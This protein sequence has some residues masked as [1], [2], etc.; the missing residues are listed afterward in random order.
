MSSI[1]ELRKLGKI[2]AFNPDEYLFYQGEIEHFA[3]LILKG[4]VSVV[5]DSAYDGS[6][7]VLAE[8]GEG[9]MVGE[10]AI[11][12]NQ[13]RSASVK[14]LEPVVALRLE[15]ES[16][17]KFLK[18]NPKYGK[19]LLRSLSQRIKATSEKVKV[20]MGESLDE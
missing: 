11:L 5:L 7:L 13:P 20:R 10:M 6:Q 4:K 19:G 2:M 16:F 3:Y 8:I 14:A 15:E 1:E 9:D 12:D 18:M 17:L